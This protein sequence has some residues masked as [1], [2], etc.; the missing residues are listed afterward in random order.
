MNTSNP[1]YEKMNREGLKMNE[2]HPFYKGM[3]SFTSMVA[4]NR[5]I[6]DRLARI[7]RQYEVD[8]SDPLDL[9]ELVDAHIHKI[10]QK[11]QRPT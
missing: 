8:I 7:L 10:I 5:L 11:L 3:T 2:G 4:L 9:P 1:I 6:E